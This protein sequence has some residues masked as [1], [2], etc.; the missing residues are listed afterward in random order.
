M[1]LEK[2]M[3]MLK[4]K[5]RKILLAIKK[6]ELIRE[7]FW[8]NNERLVYTMDKGGNENYQI[9]AT[10]LDEMYINLTPYDGIKAAILK[11]V[12]KQRL[13]NHHDE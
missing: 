12:E 5:Y 3:C 8:I 13:F 6:E 1:H 7:Y 2:S 10:D 11:T 9:F 4:Y